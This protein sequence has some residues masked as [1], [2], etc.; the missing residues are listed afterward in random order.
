MLEDLEADA[1]RSNFLK[2]FQVEVDLGDGVG[3]V[4]S[5]LRDEIS[6]ITTRSWFCDLV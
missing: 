4:S 5:A 6:N 2:V 3:E 1:R